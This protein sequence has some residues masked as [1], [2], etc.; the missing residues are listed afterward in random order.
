MFVRW[1]YVTRSRTRH[2]NSNFLIY[3]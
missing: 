2:L 1:R 3:A